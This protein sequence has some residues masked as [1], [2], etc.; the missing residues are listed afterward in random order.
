MIDGGMREFKCAAILIL[1]NLKSFFRLTGQGNPP[2][3][4]FL[5]V[6]VVTRSPRQVFPVFRHGMEAEGSVCQG[7]KRSDCKL[8]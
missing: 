8:R 6:A 4:V 2:I 5:A 7:V 3:L 1:A